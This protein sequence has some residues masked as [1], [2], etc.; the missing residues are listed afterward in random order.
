MA[1]D[2]DLPR[3]LVKRI[4][5][6][7]LASLEKEKASAEGKE[8]KEGRDIQ[9]SRDALL[10]LS[11]SA[12]VFIHYLTATG[13]VLVNHSMCLSLQCTALNTFTAS[14]GSMFL[15]CHTRGLLEFI[16]N[17]SGY[18]SPLLGKT[19]HLNVQ[20]IAFDYCRAR[21]VPGETNERASACSIRRQKE[22]S[23]RIIVH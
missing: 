5:K 14:L 3:A 2:A 20:C 17:M 7:K 16:E 8:N 23:N 15:F 4:A 12:R 18:K 6:A 21:P 22:A 9:I 10:A 1:D 19:V 13:N 11:E